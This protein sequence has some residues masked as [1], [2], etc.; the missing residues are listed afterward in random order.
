MYKLQHCLGAR[1]KGGKVRADRVNCPKNF[2]LHCKYKLEG[3]TGCPS[4]LAWNLRELFTYCYNKENSILD[5]QNLLYER[6]VITLVDLASM[7]QTKYDSVL[8]WPTTVTAKPKTSR[9]KQNSS[10]QNQKISRQ[11]QNSSRQNQKPHGKNKIPHCKTK[12][13]TAKPN[14]SHSKN[15]I[16]L[17]LP[18]VF[19]FFHSIWFSREVFGFAVRFLVL[20]WQLYGTVY[21]Q[22]REDVGVLKHL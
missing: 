15:K 3:V 21:I 14:T 18:W 1:G 13:L 11:K 17:V 7:Y 16:A 9:Q 2:V 20:P 5:L 19:A 4:S 22:W 8:W 12:N 10:R 6:C